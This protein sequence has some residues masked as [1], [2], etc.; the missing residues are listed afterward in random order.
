MPSDK[1][2]VSA[3][4]KLVIR[5]GSISAQVREAVKDGLKGV[6][7]QYVKKVKDN[8]SLDDHSLKELRE[9]GYPYSVNKPENIP[10]DDRMLHEQTGALKKSISQGRVEETTA[11]IFTVSV[12][13]DDPMIQGIIHGTSRMRPRRFHEKAYQDIK[14]KYWDPLLRKLK[15]VNFRIGEDVKHV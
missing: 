4:F 14:D 12:S 11:R 8:L 5:S 6:A 15:G 10:H 1:T 2:I 7:D 3:G 9:M 13:S